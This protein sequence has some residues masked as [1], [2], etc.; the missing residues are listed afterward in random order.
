VA[1]KE[2]GIKNKQEAI[3]QATL[4]LIAE[5]GLND[6]PM[7]LVAKHSGVSAGIIYH[8]FENKDDLIKALYYRIKSDFSEALLDG[9]LKNLPW[10]AQFKQLW[11]NAYQFYASHP[12]ETIFLE[13][14][15]NSPYYN[16][17]ESIEFNENT[18]ALGE[19]IIEN[20]K[21]GHLRPM[22]FEILYDLTLGVALSLAK[23]H[24]KGSITLENQTLDEIAEA[25]LRAVKA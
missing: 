25:C 4:E 22:S 10:P 5:R 23:R 3:L 11:L 6:T 8:Y 2:A 17:D 24:I 21:L 13:Q 1:M 12:H 15:E 16:F 19:M 9:D 7:A 14:C 20:F 18:R